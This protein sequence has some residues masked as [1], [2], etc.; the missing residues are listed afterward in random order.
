MCFVA[1]FFFT[2]FVLIFRSR[3]FLFLFLLTDNVVDSICVCALLACICV[4]V[5][6]LR[7]CTVKYCINAM[8]KLVNQVYYLYCV[9]ARSWHW[10]AVCGIWLF[11][12]E[13]MSASCVIR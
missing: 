3:F 5:P 7:S 8:I 9:G 13:F 12:V 2:G 11:D 10:I 1:C 6:I 4:Y